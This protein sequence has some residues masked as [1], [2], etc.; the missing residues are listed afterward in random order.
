MLALKSQDL[1]VK[2]L[3]L[4]LHLAALLGLLLDLV[5]RLGQILVKAFQDLGRCVDLLPH[6]VDISL[7]ALVSRQNLI[8]LGDF[9]L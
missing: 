3:C 6:Y 5:A 7:C 9:L 1:V 8:V 4:G 2:L